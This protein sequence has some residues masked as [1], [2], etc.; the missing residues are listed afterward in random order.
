[1]R[2]YIEIGPNPAEEEC[3]QVGQDDYYE[4]AREEGKRYIRA[5]IHYFGEPPALSGLRLKE[6]P[7]DFGSYFEV[8]VY[9]DDNDENSILRIST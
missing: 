3:A 8:C 9:F 4:K 1:M 5:L 2:D 6:F 7:H